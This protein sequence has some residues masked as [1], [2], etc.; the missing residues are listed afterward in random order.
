MF[1]PHTARCPEAYKSSLKKAHVAIVGAG[2][3]GSNVAMLLARAGVG[4]LTIFDFDKVEIHN[5]NRQ[6]YFTH[7]IGVHKVTALKS[8]LLDLNPEINV[9]TAVTFIDQSNVVSLLSPYPYIVEA[10]DVAETKALIVENV[11]THLQEAYVV[12]ASGMAGTG[13]ANT[14]QT[15]HPLKRLYLCGDLI[16]DVD[17]NLGLWPTRVMLCAAHQAQ[18][19]LE[20]I[21]QGGQHA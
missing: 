3:L 11:L 16:S 9:H 10:V 2:G 15:H 4:T 19:I 18:K 1:F 21:V 13:A 6:H 14:I 7:H 20:L 8:Q 5:L 12:S 17:E